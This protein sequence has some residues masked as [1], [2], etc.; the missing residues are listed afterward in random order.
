MNKKA[1]YKNNNYVWSILFSVLL[2][3]LGL[4]L[5]K[6]VYLSEE[7]I[8]ISFYQ[9]TTAPV[10][11]ACWYKTSESEEFTKERLINE[12]KAPRKGIV[13]FNIPATHLNTFR[14]DF[15]P[16]TEADIRLKDLRIQVG[17]KAHRID[18]LTSLAFILPKEAGLK[19]QKNEASW[20][21]ARPVGKITPKSPLDIGAQK[22]FSLVKFLILACSS[23]LLIFASL[24]QLI[25]PLFRFKE[26]N[27]KGNLVKHTSRFEA[28]ESLRFILSVLI[29]YFHIFSNMDSY[30]GGSDIWETLKVA[31]KPAW[32]IVECFLIMAGYFMYTA[33]KRKP[34][35]FLSFATARVVRLWPVL[36]FYLIAV[37]CLHSFKFETILLDSLFLR[38][39]GISSQ[40]GGIIWYVGPFFWGSLL[41]YC[42]LNSFDKAK[43]LLTCA[44]CVYLYHAIRTHVNTTPGELPQTVRLF[45]TSSMFRVLSGLAFGI[46]LAALKLKFIETYKQEPRFPKLRFCFISILEVFTGILLFRHFVIESTYTQILTTYI[47]FAVFFL[48]LTS[49]GGILSRLLSWKPLAYAGRYAYSIYVMQQFA[50]WWMA[51]AYWKSH[52]EILQQHPIESITVVLL[53]ALLIGIMTYYLVEAPIV[54]VYKKYFGNNRK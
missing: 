48:C 39:T 24:E 52:I 37:G 42:I 28:I 18:N 9:E 4:W 54:L 21:C 31:S 8:T 51:K 44:F 32:V 17:T 22:H 25:L 1:I 6:S 46:L 20:H 43:A 5:T 13:S 30:M 38:N 45:L 40:Y 3:I 47:L 7:K 2:T 49:S 12:K 26:S 41:L 27:S 35:G 29:V 23:F 53:V 14:L 16:V 11:F 10:H 19:I 34:Q 33:W 36:F 50:F 15:P